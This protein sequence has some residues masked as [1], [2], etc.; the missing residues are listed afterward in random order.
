M[1]M[2]LDDVRERAL[3]FLARMGERGMASVVAFGCV[4]GLPAL[5]C[6]MAGVHRVATLVPQGLPAQAPARIVAQATSFPGRLDRDQTRAAIVRQVR[7]RM[8]SHVDIER[9]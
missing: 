6:R 9:D 1:R 8:M 5:G 3:R 7:E 2:G 4:L